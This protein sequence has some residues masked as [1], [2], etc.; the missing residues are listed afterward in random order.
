MRAS[1][2]LRSRLTAVAILGMMLVPALAA[3]V[4]TVSSPSPITTYGDEIGEWW[5]D[6]SM[7]HDGDYIHDA[8]WIAAQNNHHDYLDDDGRI[9]VIV[10]FDHTPTEADQAMLELSLIHISEPTRPY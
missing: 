8:I 10:D 4:P 1:E 3:A 9:S 5:E 6:T 2:D 7:D